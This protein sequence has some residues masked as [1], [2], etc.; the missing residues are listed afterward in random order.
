M[1][2]HSFREVKPV[3]ALRLRRSS[4]W[5]SARRCRRQW[6]PAI[7]A[8]CAGVRTA[9]AI[10]CAGKIEQ[11]G[12]I[13]DYPALLGPSRACGST[14]KQYVLRQYVLWYVKTRYAVRSTAYEPNGAFFGDSRP[15]LYSVNE[16]EN[17]PIAARAFS[18]LTTVAWRQDLHQRAF[19]ERSR[20][21]VAICT[22]SETSPRYTAW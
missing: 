14:T 22:S 17:R 7:A 2:V 11:G 1:V 4:G 5:I 15:T 8:V 19:R 6:L 18:P 16:E 9:L 12:I 20:E 13:R 21:A 10:S 3:W